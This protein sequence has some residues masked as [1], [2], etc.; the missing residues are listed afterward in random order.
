MKAVL[1]GR[2][3]PVKSVKAVL[4]GKLKPMESEMLFSVEIPGGWREEV[5][6]RVSGR[7]EKP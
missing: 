1:D 6:P 5:P 7:E 2:P 4:G 3:E